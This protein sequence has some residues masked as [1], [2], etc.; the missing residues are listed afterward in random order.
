MA[1]ALIACIKHVHDN[2]DKYGVDASK[3]TIEGVS[4]GGYA[5]AAVC[6]RLAVLG[7]SNLVK[8][9]IITHGV[10]PG[11]YFAVKK[12]DMMNDEAR[13]AFYDGPFVVHG[14]ATDF[15]KQW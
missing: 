13:M 8:L 11:F 1:D 14:Y 9:A 7:Q 5:V 3:V 4:G 2:A 12:E 6:G 10:T 15:D